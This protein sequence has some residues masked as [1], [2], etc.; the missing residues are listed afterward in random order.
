MVESGTLLRCYTGNCIEGSNPSLSAML[1]LSVLLLGL[2]GGCSSE[3]EREIQWQLPLEAP[4]DPHG[5]EK[6]ANLP[7]WAESRQGEVNLVLLQKSSTKTFKM[8][9][10]SGGSAEMQ[11]WQVRLLGLASGLRIKSGAFLD[12]PNV[13]NA[14]AFVEISRDGEVAYRGWLYE[15]F[16]E[17]FG[18]DDPEWK[19]WANAISVRPAS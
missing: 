15:K 14:A 17:L 7:V 11:G 8:H 19:V 3:N 18:L 5:A 10:K 2:L 12:D 16:P 4:E 1:V 9:L 6:G 13:D